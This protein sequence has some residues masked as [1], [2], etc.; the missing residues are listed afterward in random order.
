MVLYIYIYIYIYI[1]NTHYIKRHKRNGKDIV[2]ITNPDGAEHKL[3]MLHVF[4]LRLEIF[5]LN[6]MNLQYKLL[7]FDN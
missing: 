3:N 2:H 4:C 7:P 6:K 5:Q 1:Y